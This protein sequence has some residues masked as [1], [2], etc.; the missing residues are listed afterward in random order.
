[1][2]EKELSLEEVLRGVPPEKLDQP[3]QDEHLCDVAR[4][5]T[6]WPS[7]APLLGISRAEMEEIRGKW[8]FSV[9]GQKIEFLR[10]WQ[11]KQGRKATY[12]KLCKA[13]YKA[14]DVTLAE[15]ACD[16]LTSQGSSSS[17]SSDDEEAY[18]TPP[19]CNE[20]EDSGINPPRREKEEPLKE[21]GPC[22]TSPHPTAPPPPTG[23]DL[24]DPGNSESRGSETCTTL[25]P[26][27]QPRA[28]K[29]SR[30]LSFLLSK[31]RTSKEAGAT[32]KLAHKPC[33]PP[34]LTPKPTPQP[35]GVAGLSG[36]DHMPIQPG[37][38]FAHDVSPHMCHT[39][40]PPPTTE[41]H[42]LDPYA[43]YLRDMYDIIQLQSL[44]LQWPP[45]PT[46][47]VFNLAMFHS[48]DVQCGPVNEELVRLLQRGNVAGYAR[49]RVSV[50]L[51]NLLELDNAKRKIVLIEGAPGSGKST[52]AWHACQRWK[53]RELFQDFRMV[54][55]VQLRDPRVQSA[56]SIADLLPAGPEERRRDAAEG[57][58]AC[59][60]RG[61]L[62]VMDGWDEFG[63]GLK[64]DSIVSKLICKS[65]KLEVPY[66]ALLITS[67]PIA[68]ASLQPLVS[69]R[70]EIV[71]FTPEEVSQYFQEAVKDPVAV[72]ALQEQ[73]KG[74]PVIEASC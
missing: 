60:G 34:H 27:P 37:G 44:V 47:R 33:P 6:D 54:V 46:R 15:K 62:F 17:D 11:E 43:I 70:V 24:I 31:T 16:V 58:K 39:A 28:S 19:E 26:T 13:L 74:L 55:V 56:Q 61:V 18:F 73:L 68:S 21:V 38:H 30:W 36:S 7:L 65:D 20:D 42:P 64:S 45:P 49:K 63:P 41:V 66:S 67:R 5:V 22:P 52:L 4:H 72:Q 14:G 23:G 59:G 69:S 71:G 10:K 3:C 2:A 35:G 29:L 40:P 51:C 8:P 57:I 50:Q 48:T 12:R 9:L 25:R 32:R 53:T 1:M